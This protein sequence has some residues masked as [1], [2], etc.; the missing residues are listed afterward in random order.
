M[1]ERIHIIDQDA[2]RQA[3]ITAYFSERAIE[4]A[5]HQSVAEFV[6]A[7]P[8]GGLVF[9]ADLG[10]EGSIAVLDHLESAGA[11]VLYA[12]QPAPERI[13][14]AMLRGALDY[15][16]WPFNPALLA[17]AIERQMT[18]GEGRCRERELQTSAAAQI[19]L[20]TPRERD[21]LGHLALGKSNKAIANALRIS[22][23]TVE[24][25]R[26]KMMRKLGARA[27]SGAVRVALYAGLDREFHPIG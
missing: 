8:G 2:G 22:P 10:S 1:R 3:R 15:L 19:G 24:I 23:R 5:V 18:M 11:V 16:E 20:L 26:G 14:N 21:V 6:R 27:T 13:V 7:C 4:T 25:H 9:A 17:A 12:D